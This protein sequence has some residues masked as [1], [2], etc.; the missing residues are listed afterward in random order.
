M[1]RAF[2]RGAIMAVMAGSLGA[3]MAAGPVVSASGAA[4]AVHPVAVRQPTAVAIDPTLGRAAVLRAAPRHALA[5]PAAPALRICSFDGTRSR[6]P[7]ATATGDLGYDQLRADLLD[8]AKFGPTGTVH[9]TVVIEPGVPTITTADLAGCNV[10]FTSVFTGALSGSEASALAF[11]WRHKGM[12]LI[13][14]ADSDTD[15]Q[16]SVNSILTALGRPAAFTGALACPEGRVRLNG[17][18]D[19]AV[20]GPFGDLRGNTWGT[21]LSAEMTI[22]GRAMVRCGTSI[23]RKVIATK[24]FV[25]GDP[26]GFGLF[27]APGGGAYDPTNEAAYLNFIGAAR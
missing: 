26:S 2:R 18:S 6:A 9:R 23:V 27:T 25:G 10:F 17:P 4:A 19:V 7:F 14:D 1:R 21:S 13:T 20:F 11:A 3:V 12:A 8:P 16:V 22:P 24:L 5:T 15:E